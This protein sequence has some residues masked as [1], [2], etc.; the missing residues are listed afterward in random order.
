MLRP[1]P[2]KNIHPLRRL[3]HFKQCYRRFS[4]QHS[5]PPKDSRSRLRKLNDHLPPFLRT[6]TSRLLDAPVTHVTS[7]LIL[8]E[9]TAIVPLF[10]LVAAF[11]YGNW[12]PD[13]GTGAS[14]NVFDEA[15]GRFGRWLRKKGW[16]NDA[17]VDGALDYGSGPDSSHGN[18]PIEKRQQGEVKGARLILE[19]ASAYVITKALLP[20]R[21]VASVWATPW[22]ARTILGPVSQ[23]F[24]NLTRRK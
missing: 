10:G 6:Y 16:V 3:S 21:V 17:D 1:R 4:T 8:H 19:F 11:H 12:M 9:L 15:V 13:F 5:Q 14:G 2:L 23:G 18:G 22:F 24:R 7:F 20:V